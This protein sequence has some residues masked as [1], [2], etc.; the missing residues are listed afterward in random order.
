MAEYKAPVKEMNFVLE[1]IA[2]MPG[3][4]QLSGYEEASPDMVTAILEEAGRVSAEVLSPLNVVGDETGVRLEGKEVPTPEGF[5]EAYQQY[6]EGGWGSLQFDPEYGGQGL[7]YALSIPVMEMWQ[8]ANMA[9]GLCPLLSQ[10]AVEAV[11]A[12]LVLR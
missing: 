10:G 2:D 7:P 12:R 9:W 6:A 11:D 4:A 1:H 8:A 5:K 3:L